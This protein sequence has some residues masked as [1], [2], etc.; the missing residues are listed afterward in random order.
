MGVSLLRMALEAV[1][2]GGLL[3]GKR[4]INFK[5]REGNGCVS[6]TESW[7]SHPLNYISAQE[8]TACKVGM[9]IVRVAKTSRVEPVASHG[10]CIISS[11]EK[12]GFYY[13]FPKWS[14]FIFHSCLLL[15]QCSWCSLSVLV[16]YLAQALPQQLVW[17]LGICSYRKGGPE[18]SLESLHLNMLI[19]RWES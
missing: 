3:F 11:I 9:N 13:S 17:S 15:Q 5:S 14:P 18:G 10:P 7:E 6:N 2:M 19:F 4:N 8:R 16:I 12:V 1:V